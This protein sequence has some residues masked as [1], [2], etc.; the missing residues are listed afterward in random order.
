MKLWYVVGIVVL[1]LILGSG[2]STPA[3]RIKKEA[4]IDAN[5]FSPNWGNPVPCDDEPDPRSSMD[6]LQP[7][8][9]GGETS[10]PG[11]T[12]NPTGVSVFITYDKT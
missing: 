12:L 9:A 7:L 10:A 6:A 1:L 4:C 5:V 2:E 3:P 8:T 11:P